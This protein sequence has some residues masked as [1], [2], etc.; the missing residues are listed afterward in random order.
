MENTEQKKRESFESI[1]KMP[2]SY[3]K[4]DWTFTPIRYRGKRV[5][6]VQDYDQDE[7]C[8]K[9]FHTLV[10]YDTNKVIK[11]IDWS[12]YSEMSQR[13]LALYLK[14]DCPDRTAL[15]NSGPLDYEDLLKIQNNREILR[16]AM[17]KLNQGL[18]LVP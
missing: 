2:E 6:L 13:D 3:Y 15:K 9:I 4:E 14:L 1:N 12:S 11:D 16:K 17:E 18:D 7:D 5:K 10:D 8:T